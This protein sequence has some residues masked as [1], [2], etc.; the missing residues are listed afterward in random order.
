MT[1]PAATP[2]LAA[3]TRLG[4]T[5]L[6]VSDLDRSLAFYQD[7]IGLRVH[8]HEDGAAALGAGG[9]DVLVLHEDPAARP[10]ARHAGLYHVALL[11]PSR[12]ELAFAVARLVR[13][14]TPVQGMSDHGTH[15]AIYL[16]DPDGNG[17]ELAADRPRSEWPAGLGYSGGPAPLDVESLY[18]LAHGADV[19]RF[20]GEGLR[21]G[22]LHLHVSQLDAARDFYRDVI[23][24][25]VQFEM[26]TAVFLSAGGYHHHIAVNT[27]RG[28]GV[29]AVPA[30]GTVGMRHWTVVVSAGD[31]AA[32]ASRAGASATGGVLELPDPSGNVIRLEAS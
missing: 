4:A 13:A 1:S 3:T 7:A 5:H 26:P 11:Y 22:H 8:R 10:A 12:Q 24:F 32:I 27:W 18:S 6:T 23:G 31:L 21:T 28:R 2:A 29:P 25:E 30:S 9:E 19:P 17:L 20:V 14:R 16:P 15:E